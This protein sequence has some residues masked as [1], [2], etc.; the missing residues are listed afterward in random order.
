MVRAV[1][2]VRER[3]HRSTQALEAAGVPYAVIGGNAVAAW[4]SK[5]DP[6]AARNTIDVDLI[7][8]RSDLEAAK[9]AMAKA[10][11][12]YHYS[13]GVHTFLDGPDGRPRDAVHIIFAGEMVDPRY[14]APAPDLSESQQH[15]TYRLLE[16]ES[17]VRMKLTSFR[18]K[19]QVHIQDMIAVGL[20][21]QS[22]TTRFQP[23]LAA[24][25]QELLDDPEG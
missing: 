24:K 7:V 1:E 2:K 16:L 15:D 6:G 19:D 13:Y 22:W 20:I 12:E 25:L 23:P 14:S 3:L 17:L 4:V 18:R 8:N 21:D 9:T 5:V 11:F 10:G